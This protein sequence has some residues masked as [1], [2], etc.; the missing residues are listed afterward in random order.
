MF[1]PPDSEQSED[2]EFDYDE[3]SNKSV[4]LQSFI[5]FNE[6]KID[7]DQLT[8]KNISELDQIDKP[9]LFVDPHDDEKIGSTT[10]SPPKNLEDEKI[11]KN[12]KVMGRKRKNSGAIEIIKTDNPKVHD[13]NSEDNKMRKLKTNIME[14]QILNKLNQS[15]TDKSLQFYRLHTDVSE[16]LKKNFNEDL[17]GTTVRELFNNVNISEKYRTYIDPLSNRK[18]INKIDDEK[19]ETE[20]IKILDMT[21][22]GVILKVREENMDAFLANIKNKEIKMKNHDNIDEYMNSLKGLLLNFEE[23]FEN[24]KS[25][26]R[27][28]KK[29]STTKKAL[30]KQ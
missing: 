3:S 15:L 16:N 23:W 12:K 27:E 6:P 25:R 7:N 17:M 2:F 28:K 5:N 19:K 24:K 13:R 30:D 26:N 4:S 8:N 14:H 18:L 22:S 10:L 20:T 29:K 21:Y 9:K 1:S 11:L